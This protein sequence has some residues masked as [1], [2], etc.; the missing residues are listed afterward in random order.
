MN[1]SELNFLKDGELEERLKESASG[2][3]TAREIKAQ[4]ISWIYGQLM[5]SPNITRTQVEE[6]Y[7]RTHGY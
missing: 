2:K 7:A 1:L 5:N 6:A 4:K 3:M